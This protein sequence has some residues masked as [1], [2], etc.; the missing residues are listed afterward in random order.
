M[1]ARFAPLAPDGGAEDFDRLAP[2]LWNTVGNAVVAAADVLLGERVLDV[3]AGTGS[4]TIPAAQLAGPAGRVDAVDSSGPMLDFARSKAEAMGLENIGFSAQDLMEFSGNLPYDAVLCCYGLFHAPDM[5]AATLQISSLLHPDG[6][7]ALSTWDQEAL[8]PF[9]T[10]LL[11]AC[12]AE[13]PNSTPVRPGSFISNRRELTGEERLRAWLGRR[14]FT[15]IT[16]EK[17]ALAVPLDAD[18]A[19]SLVL[20]SGYRGILPSDPAA[21]D[22]VRTRFLRDLGAGFVLRADSLIAVARR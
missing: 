16:V 4:A 11:E 7:L 22:R 13:A 9:E 2:A 15:R 1:T 20:G 3:Y 19:W 6:R 14:S 18:A 21:I 8:Q 10:L 12:E 5:S 17:L